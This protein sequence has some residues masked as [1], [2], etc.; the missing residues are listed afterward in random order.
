M[1][2]VRLTFYR[3]K[4]LSGLFLPDG[5]SVNGELVGKIKSGG[6]LAVEVPKADRYYLTGLVWGCDVDPFDENNAV[7]FDRGDPEYRVLLKRVGGRRTNPRYRFYL[8]T[9]EQTVPLPAFHFEKFSHAVWG[10][11]IQEL[12]AS[13]RLLAICAEF[14]FGVT[15]ELQEVLASESLTE[16][17]DVLQEIGATQLAGTLRRI[18]DEWFAD[19]ALPL[20][21]KQIKQLRDRIRKAHK[22]V[23]ELP[24]SAWDEF[25]AGVA[26]YIAANL[27]S[28]EYIY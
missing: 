21:D 2:T 22:R 18:R 7:L 1:E 3:K 16:I 10:D 24:R 15:D 11:H 17:L 13:E 14:W 8:C 25:R 9:G 20:N 26:K 23:C 12:S 6:T 5:I 4:A 27:N 19:V 28:E